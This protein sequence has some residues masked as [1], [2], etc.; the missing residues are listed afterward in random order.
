MTSDETLLAMVRL[1]AG[2]TPVLEIAKMYGKT[3]QFVSTTTNRIK[4]ADEDYVGRSLTKEYW[5][6]KRAAS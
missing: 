6:I 2:G 4:R 1:R 5:P 3:L